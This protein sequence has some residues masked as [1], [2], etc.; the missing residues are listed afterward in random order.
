MSKKMTKTKTREQIIH[1]LKMDGPQEASALAEPL[2]LT[3]MAVRQHLYD[4]EKS[5]E[6]SH[7]TVP[8]PKGRPAKVWHLTEKSNS[9]FADSHADLA[10]GLIASVRQA[11]G[12][13]GM[14][15]LLEI[16]YHEQVEDYSNRLMASKNLKE[17][18]ENLAL[19]RSREGYMAEVLDGEDQG[20]LFVEN[21]CPVC[22]VAKSCSGICAR[23]LDVFQEIMGGDVTVRRSEHI[24]QGARRCAYEVRPK[25]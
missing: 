24:M 20:F 4:L 12:E 21:H 14:D 16:R 25:S 7:N 23:E 13:E 22:Q 19:I 17:K 3:D 18:L 8:R 11:F 15:K 5:G 10:L 1:R 2:G 6:I 9:H